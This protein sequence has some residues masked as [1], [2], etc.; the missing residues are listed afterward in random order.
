MTDEIRRALGGRVR[1]VL[2]MWEQS[3][4][5][6]VKTAGDPLG[7]GQSGAWLLP[8]RVT[9]DG[10]LQ[11]AVLK[12]CPAEPGGP[13]RE[14]GAHD[15]AM[16]CSPSTFAA[17]HL[18]DRVY[19]PIVLEDGSMLLFLRIASGSLVERAPLRAYQDDAAL[20]PALREIVRSVLA[21]WNTGARGAGLGLAQVSPG[22]FLTRLLA[23]RLE[24]AH[25]LTRWLGEQ[26]GVSR[27][28][29]LYLTIPAFEQ[30]LVNPVALLRN[31]D[32]IG[33]LRVPLTT[34]LAHGDLHLDNIIVPRRPG[35]PAAF[36]LID[37]TTFDEAAPL[38]RDP[39]HLLL[40]ACG[41][42]LPRLDRA[43]RA[44]L[45]QALV[46][47]VADPGLPAPLTAATAAVR[48][49][50][51]EAYAAGERTDDWH[52]E[53]MLALVAAGLM[54]VGRAQRPDDA[55]WYFEVAAQAATRFLA[56][57]AGTAARPP[58]GTVPAARR[59][60]EPSS[61][62]RAEPSSTPPARAEAATPAWAEAATPA[63]AEVPPA[64][65]ALSDKEQL[66]AAVLAVLAKSGHPRLDRLITHL[67]EEI[68]HSLAHSGTDSLRDRVVDLI[69]VL[70]AE[71]GWPSL[72]DAM[73]LVIGPGR[74]TDRLTELTGR[75]RG[76]R[77]P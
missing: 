28:N 45:I 36:R 18:V 71:D 4:G 49:G 20:G 46:N 66:V 37:L 40:S 70:D 11:A 2:S 31:R 26:P 33:R 27:A 7:G 62:P 68:R 72:L 50:G 5:R 75:L 13:A 44:R 54:F 34:G 12:F 10:R 9:D 51:A 58:A 1:H 16:R 61:T 63:S 69:T 59:P 25:R 24:P 19:D 57:S 74:A 53:R 8:V 29:G 17:D 47:D 41:P 55:W 22:E 52:V 73:R 48:E 6:T 23:H 65:S 42:H 21:D 30:T 76:L 32:A 60:A 14:P 43:A 77:R 39:M 35:D 15:R 56:D 64:A 3:T 67:P 38:A